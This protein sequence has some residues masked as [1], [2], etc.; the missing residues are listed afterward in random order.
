MVL[1]DANHDRTV[2]IL[3]EYTENLTCADPLLR[4]DLPA[5]LREQPLLGDG[6]RSA[7]ILPLRLLPGVVR[8]RSICPDCDS[9]RP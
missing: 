3:Q 9:A 7:A 8:P 2:R 4:M 5:R 1:G 6:G